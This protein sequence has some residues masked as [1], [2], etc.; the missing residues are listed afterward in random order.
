MEILLLLAGVAIGMAVQRFVAKRREAGPPPVSEPEKQVESVVPPPTPQV[1]EDL[2]S[3]L[4]PLR[5]EIETFGES[6]AHPREI[7]ERAEFRKAVELL[8]D[9][10]TSTQVLTDYALGTNW[11]LSS[12]AFVAAASR[13]DGPAVFAAVLPRLRHLGNTPL[14][15]ALHAIGQLSERPPVGAV[16]LDPDQYWDDDAG[17]IAS[18]ESYL[19][20]RQ[21]LGDAPTFGDSLAKHREPN[22]VRVEALLKA[23]DHPS[24]QALLA[25]LSHWRGNRLNRDFLQSIGQFWTEEG[26]DLL[27]EHASIREPL[28]TLETAVT[29]S[30]PRSVLVVGEARTGK[31]SLLRLLARRLGPQ[32]YTV[33]E[34]GGAQ[35]MAG[36][37]YFGELE[38]RIRRIQQ[39]LSSDKR[40]IWY[41]PDFLHIVTSGTHSG[42][43]ASILDQVLPAVLSGHLIIV[44]ECTPGVLVKIHQTRAAL[45]NAMDV[46]RLRATTPQETSPI[47]DEFS[48]CVEKALN[49]QVQTGVVPA[50]MQLSAQY[51]GGQQLPGAVID[52]IKMAANRVLA[53]AEPAVTRE[54]LLATLSQITGMPRTFSTIA[55]PDLAELR[56]SSAH[57]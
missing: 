32:G 50:A 9:A 17:V 6:S 40:V 29:H 10:S 11:P 49:V 51:L 26:N 14:Y 25:E 43:A 38:G 22:V 48:R 3:R 45:R 21:E 56:R 55:R 19:R 20:K 54:S 5:K 31:T 28:L 27:V 35:L 18:F 23:I 34:A 24:S 42:Q 33:F 13:S 15:F 37:S 36:Q 1:A 44:G 7:A 41:V 4:I 57:A 47:V 12:A 2:A 53:N 30:P 16:F 46:V 39:E 52:L 8:A